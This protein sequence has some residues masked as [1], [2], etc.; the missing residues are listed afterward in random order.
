MRMLFG[1]LAGGLLVVAVAAWRGDQPIAALGAAVI[2][3]WLGA[4]AAR[5]IRRR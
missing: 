4:Q 2:G 3:A 5:G 1:A